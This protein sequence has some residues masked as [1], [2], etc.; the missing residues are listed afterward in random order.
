MKRIVFV[1]FC[2]LLGIVLFGGTIPQQVNEKRDIPADK[3]LVIALR[4]LNTEQF[5][6][7]D[8]NHRFADRDQMLSFLREDGCLRKSPLDLEKPKPYELT[9]TTSAD[10]QH[11]QITLR[12]SAA[13]DDQN[14]DCQYAAF[15]DDGAVIY[16]GRALGC[17]PATAY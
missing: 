13:P 17:D 11:Y 9:I 6:Y 10:G 14:G 7:M 16:L 5:N 8:K 15:T 12:R 2:G 4:L 3:K 1:L